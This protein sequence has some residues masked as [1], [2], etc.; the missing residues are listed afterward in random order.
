M[1]FKK[2]DVSEEIDLCIALGKADVMPHCAGV[3]ILEYVRRCLA[4]EKMLNLNKTKPKRHKIR[5]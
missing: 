5:K 3:V 2:N 1:S 4:Y